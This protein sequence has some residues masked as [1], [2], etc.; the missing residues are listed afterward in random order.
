MNRNF[1]FVLFVGLLFPVSFSI[2]SCQTNSSEWKTKAEN[3]EFVHRSIRK[4]IDIMRHDIFAPPVASRIFAYS[5]IAGYE[6]LRPGYAGNESFAGKLNQLKPV[7]QPEAGKEYCFPLASMT[8][9]TVVGQAL[10][11]SEAD[12]AELKA[13]LTKDFGEMGVPKEVFERSVAYG[14][15]VAKHILAWAKTDNYAQIRSAPKFSI[16]AK[17]AGRWVPTPPRY[18]DALEPHWPEMR[19]WLMDSAAQFKPQLPIEFSTAKGSEF[20]NAAQEV[21]ETGKN[22]TE[23]QRE[24]AIYWDDNPFEV[25]VSGHLMIGMKKISPGGHWMNIAASVSRKANADI[26]KSMKTYATVACGLAEAF[27]SCWATKY[28]HTVVR[29]VTYIN[30]YIDPEWQPLIETPPFPEH[31][32]GHATVSSSAATVLTNIYGENFAFTDS[33]EVEF[34]MAPRTF[35]NFFEASDEAAVSRMYGGIHYR[36][37]NEAGRASGREIGK[38]VFEKLK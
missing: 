16:D 30:S 7:P 24:T 28:R 27:I 26:L 33:T 15:A 21:R 34:G 14:D 25:S 5:S 31:T 9:I 38:F 29:P 8:A 20:Y 4:I 2:S 12:M 36:R 17:I 1:I 22:L 11:F 37:G 6:A 23:A 3:P 13:E 19:P 35:K 18:E 32:S 10:I